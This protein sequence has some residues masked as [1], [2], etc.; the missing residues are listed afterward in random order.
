MLFFYVMISRYVTCFSN[1]RWRFLV[2]HACFSSAESV[3]PG[4]PSWP[5]VPR[6]ADWESAAGGA[7]VATVAMRRWDFKGRLLN[8]RKVE[9]GDVRNLGKWRDFVFGKL[10]CLLT[11]K[12]AQNPK[13]LKKCVVWL[14]FLS[15]KKK[16][17]QTPEWEVT[18]PQ[19]TPPLDPVCFLWPAVGGLTF[20]ETVSPC[21]GVPIAYPAGSLKIDVCGRGQNMYHLG[22]PPSQ[23]S[24]GKWRFIGIPY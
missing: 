6:L 1:R 15:Q 19:Q 16:T 22:C 12:H 24:S 4:R 7:W 13:P 3:P 21:F 14:S 10:E 9:F 8:V 2:S 17:Y 11:K 18:A 23:D 5:T 20:G